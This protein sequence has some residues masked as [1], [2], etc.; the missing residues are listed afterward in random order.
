MNKKIILIVLVLV[1]IGLSIY[2]YMVLPE[3]VTVQIDMSG[4]PS[5]F[6]PKTLVIA[7]QLLLS[8]GGGI[9]YYFSKE[10]EKKF[11]VLSIGGIIVSVITLVY[12]V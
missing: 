9:G 4:N 5:N 11:L 6:Y 7:S 2:G 1:S 3:T 12:N 8:I 10:K